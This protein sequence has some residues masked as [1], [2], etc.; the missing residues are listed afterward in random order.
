VLSAWIWV[1]LSEE[2]LVAL[3]APIWVEVRAADGGGVNLATSV[4]D[5]PE[6]GF[7]ARPCSWVA[8]KPLMEVASARA[9]LGW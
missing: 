2:K 8:F 9:R 3:S 7:V 5:R 4:V 6:A 1:T